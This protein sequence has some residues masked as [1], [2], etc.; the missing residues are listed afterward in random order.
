MASAFTKLFLSGHRKRAGLSAKR[1]DAQR[2]P[3]PLPHH[4]HPSASHSISHSHS[5]SSSSSTGRKS[6]ASVRPSFQGSIQEESPHYAGRPGAHRTAFLTTDSL[7]GPATAE[8]LPYPGR[9]SIGERRRSSTLFDTSAPPESASASGDLRRTSAH[10]GHAPHASAA[11][12]ATTASSVGEP[13]SPRQPFPADDEDDIDDNPLFLRLSEDPSLAHA[14]DA[15]RLVLVPLRRCLSFDD[16]DQLACL[17]DDAY[18][19]LHA[20][21]PSRLFKNQYISVRS[22]GEAPGATSATDGCDAQFLAPE[23]QRSGRWG[24][25]SVTATLLPDQ[26]AVSVSIARSDAPAPA[27]HTLRIVAETTVYR[28]LAAPNVAQSAT[29]ASQPS[30]SSNSGFEVVSRPGSSRSG[31][32]P[33]KVK[34]RVV[35]VEGIVVGPS[36][37]PRE[38]HDRPMYADNNADP[39]ASDLFGR[40]HLHPGGGCGRTPS[41]NISPSGSIAFPSTEHD[42]AAHLASA[43][44]TSSMSRQLSSSSHR[45][46]G[47]GRRDNDELRAAASYSL[48]EAILDR[49]PAMRS[50]IDDLY[51]L[52]RPPAEL[53]ELAIPLAKA[54]NVLISA[55]LEFASAFVFVKGFERYNVSR[56]RRGILR[57]ASMELEAALAASH[58]SLSAEAAQRLEEVLENVVLGYIHPKLYGSTAEQL[59]EADASLDEALALYDANGVGLIELGVHVPTLR[60]R[61]GRLEGAIAT[62]RDGLSMHCP[63]ELDEALTASSSSDRAALLAALEAYRTGAGADGVPDASMDSQAASDL[64]CAMAASLHLA[65]PRPQLADDD[66]SERTPPV[67]VRTPPETVQALKAT[68]D[69]I[70]LAVQRSH[71]AS[72]RT[73]LSTMEQPPLL[74]TDDLLPVLAYVIVKARPAKLVSCLHYAKAFRL[75]EPVPS[76]LSWALVTFE[77]VVEYLKGDPLGIKRSCSIDADFG[78][79]RSGG[80]G[81]SS[82]HGSIGNASMRSLPSR[83]RS[84]T[85]ASH[86]YHSVSMSR[87]SS[88]LRDRR[89]SIPLAS[90][91]GTHS[92]TSPMSPSSSSGGAAFVSNN[93]GYFSRVGEPAF[94]PPESALDDASPTLRQDGFRLPGST[95]TS[96]SLTRPSSRTW[97]RPG[98]I[99]TLNGDADS[100]LSH[101]RL[102][103]ASQAGSHSQ[104]QSQSLSRHSSI[105]GRTISLNAGSSSGS[106]G[107]LQI[108]PQIILAGRRPYAGSVSQIDLTDSSG[109]VPQMER[110]SSS[111]G[112]YNVRV[113]GS[114]P[115]GSSSPPKASRRKSMDSW[116]ALS[117]FGGGRTSS[118]GRA[119]VDVQ[120][121]DDQPIVRRVG[122]RPL[123]LAESAASSSEG[124][125]TQVAA[126]VAAAAS[127]SSSWLPWS[128]SDGGSG[129]GSGGGNGSANRRPDT[130]GTSSVLSAEGIPSSSSTYSSM[131]RSASGS[132]FAS[133]TAAS[134]SLLPEG[135]PPLGSEM[136]VP[137]TNVGASGSSRRATSIRSVSS[138]SSGQGGDDPSNGGGSSS[139]GASSLAAQLQAAQST[140]QLRVPPRRRYR[141]RFL[142]ATSGSNVPAAPSPPGVN[143][144]ATAGDISHDSEQRSFGSLSAVMSTSAAAA[145]AAQTPSSS[146]SPTVTTP[147]L[148]GSDDETAAAATTTS[149]GPGAGTSVEAATL[150]VPVT[151][152]IGSRASGADH[153]AGLGARWLALDDALPPFFRLH[154]PSPV[155]EIA[156]PLATSSPSSA[157]WT[158]IATPRAQDATH[159]TLA[160]PDSGVEVEVEAVEV[161]AHPSSPTVGTTTPTTMS[162]QPTPVEFDL[163]IFQQVGG[164]G[165]EEEGESGPAKGPDLAA[166]VGVGKG[167]ATF[168]RRSAR[169]GP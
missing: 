40:T 1:D 58:A 84:A 25:V 26:H 150:R 10:G 167:R 50:F 110:A 129:G 80:G 106:G 103:E 59:A 136:A 22:V 142:S 55:A 71:L 94:Q 8:D 27:E 105:R 83:H 147:S 62:L 66:R 42:A 107:E 77:A 168:K 148:P 41:R 87:A 65:S 102:A 99:C 157:S 166:L 162:H 17:D 74:S 152:G 72:S 48:S 13:A 23:Q 61:P 117:I 60:H 54:S 139:I 130:P 63:A 69:E 169:V 44:P 14:W 141:A 2:Q 75:L 160:R 81:T 124:Q 49:V 113:V 120:T 127:S 78:G 12:A 90:P 144:E 21:A 134:S 70:G 38:A 146:A 34:V 121:C 56:I 111:T 156:D 158:P 19:A 92:P 51:L 64:A 116:T 97:H 67:K 108:R 29:A 45:S 39:A 122:A 145:A 95:S 43:G 16:D 73:S 119:S 137:C 125:V 9:P 37:L 89:A 53:A 164:V 140:S 52:L 163:G 98:S 46:A 30:S 96:A 32:K 128:T 135:S 31:A 161:Q 91:D 114:P 101:E 24:Q 11:S 123:S 143:L 79:V 82:R 165:G 57:K 5:S 76:D 47:S 3:H 154:V 133:I 86:H 15:A 35:S 115:L 20:L 126:A 68:I 4:A 7:N 36:P 159:P 118:E 28:T 18:V 109:A 151:P 138:L 149:K 112:H 100:V 93:A 88:D 132:G 6:F 155:K 104:S 33:E 85:A 153:V 131:T